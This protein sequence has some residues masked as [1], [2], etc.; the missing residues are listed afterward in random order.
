MHWMWYVIHDNVTSTKNA[1]Y[2]C[3]R[4][5]LDCPPGIT[6]FGSGGSQVVV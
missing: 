1:N 2:H 4:M 3:K 5:Q 6:V